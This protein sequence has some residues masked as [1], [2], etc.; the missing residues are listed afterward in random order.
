MFK[1]QISSNVRFTK[2]TIIE[3]LARKSTPPPYFWK[4]PLIPLI[5]IP[6]STKKIN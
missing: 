2:K 5:S 6:T 3:V 4:N 1:T